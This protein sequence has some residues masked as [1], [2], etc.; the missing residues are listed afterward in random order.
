MSSP[1]RS[2]SLVLLFLIGIM[3]A[4]TAAVMAAIPWLRQQP[5]ELALLLTGIAAT[6]TV[7]A[8]VA[9]G[10]LNDRKLDEWQRTNA[11]FAS[12]WGWTVGAGL[13][14][15]LLVLPPVQ[16]LIVS[17]AVIWGGTPD[18]DVR[19]VLT[20]FTFGFMAAVVTQTICTALLSLGWHLWMSRAPRDLQ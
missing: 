15:L 2:R 6:L 16:G 14:A 13:F 7:L 5:D 4:P 18:P 12:Q 1:D 17:G 8:S 9:L 20:T 11:R 19:L 3:I 10:V